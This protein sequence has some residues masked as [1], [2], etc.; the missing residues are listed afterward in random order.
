VSDKSI[1][2]VLIFLT[3]CTLQGPMKLE[4]RFLPRRFMAIAAPILSSLIVFSSPTVAQNSSTRILILPF[5]SLETDDAS[6]M[7]ASDLFHIFIDTFDERPEIDV[8]GD[9]SAPLTDKSFSSKDMR[10]EGEK[11]NVNWVMAGELQGGTENWVLFL[12]VM[13]P[14]DSTARQFSVSGTSTYDLVQTVQDWVK[15][16]LEFLTTTD[17]AIR[18][19]KEAE[20]DQN[21]AI[22]YYKQARR[23]KGNDTNTINKKIDLLQ[24]AIDLAP[25]FISAYQS[26]G[27]AYQQI[28]NYTAALDAYDMAVQIKPTYS[29]AHYNMGTVYQ[30]LRD[31]DKAAKA[32]T[33]AIEVKPDYKEAWFNLAWVMKY[34]DKGR[35]YGDGFDADSVEACLIHLLK[36]DPNFMRTY[37]ALGNLY[38]HVGRLQEA[39]DIV[40]ESISQDKNYAD[41]WYTLAILNDDYIGNYPDAINCYEKYI[42]LKGQR[43]TGARNRINYLK[44]K[45]AAQDSLKEFQSQQQSSLSK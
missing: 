25:G 35:E 31:W 12:R 43:S 40:E 36:I 10:A 20:I 14:K 4:K 29:L 7:L 18:A 19:Q 11:A 2:K 30:A 32:Y 24:K 27:F 23:L 1:R 38:M 44:S 8:A 17:P 16:N 5:T 37:T 42:A 15:K 34:N 28:Q 3:K 9:H 39:K 6:E 41:G 21:N 45:M 13:D 26:L 33:K 22:S